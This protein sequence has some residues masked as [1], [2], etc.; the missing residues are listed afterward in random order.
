MIRPGCAPA[1][2]VA[3]LSALPT[4]TAPSAGGRIDQTTMRLPGLVATRALVV[5]PTRTLPGSK[6]I[7]GPIS[8]CCMRSQ[9]SVKQPGVAVKAA[10]TRTGAASVPALNSAGLP[11]A[12]MVTPNAGPGSVQVMRL[13]PG[14]DHILEKAIGDNWRR[15]LDANNLRME[16][17]MPNTY[18]EIIQ[19]RHPELR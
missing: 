9:P 14:L 8:T 18:R 1:V 13:P 3:E 17:S 6:R 4:I 19:A 16:F 12:T 5:A 15:A 2:I 11:W 10:R 7:A